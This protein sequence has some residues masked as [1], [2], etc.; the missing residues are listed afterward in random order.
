MDFTDFFL[1]KWQDTDFPVFE[2]NRLF[3]AFMLSLVIFAGP[4]GFCDYYKTVQCKYHRH[5]TR[6]LSWSVSQ[7]LVLT[8]S[9][10]WGK[11]R[12]PYC[13]SLDD[14]EET[15]WVTHVSCDHRTSWQEV[16]RVSIE[17]P[18]WSWQDIPHKC[19]TWMWTRDGSDV[20][21]ETALCIQPGVCS[22]HKACQVQT[23]IRGRKG[24]M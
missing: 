15:L 1:L 23:H 9:R 13:V 24:E 11:S 6:Q 4:P 16:E 21:E 10:S 20:Q 12:E 19:W 7:R 8:Q 3:S 22:G 2:R 5:F 18:G 17:T 14:P